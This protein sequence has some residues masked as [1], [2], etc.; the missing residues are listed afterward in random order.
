[1]QEPVG[2]PFHGFIQRVLT[3]GNPQ[4]SEMR[5]Q[6]LGMAHE[7]LQAASNSQFRASLALRSYGLQCLHSLAARFA[8]GN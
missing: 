7:M 1:M 4:R 8:S 5:G 6:R 3:A 2:G